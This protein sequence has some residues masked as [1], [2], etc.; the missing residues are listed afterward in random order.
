MTA[1]APS[2]PAASCPPSNRYKYV[3]KRGKYVPTTSQLD[4]TTSSRFFTVSYF[5][6]LLK[7]ERDGD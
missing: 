5:S 2:A 4:V 3:A 1:P 7:E 6:N